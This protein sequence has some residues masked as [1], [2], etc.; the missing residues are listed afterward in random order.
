M[1]KQQTL[2]QQSTLAGLIERL[3]PSD[4]SHETDISDLYLTRSSTLHL[5]R[6]AL[7]Q[8]V[9]CIVA[10]GSKSILLNGQRY[11]YDPSTYL[12]VS[13]DLPL[14]GQLE[15]ASR[16]KP[17]LGWS[18]V[19]N[20][21]EID[22]LLQETKLQRPVSDPVPPR[23]NHRI[24]GRGTSRCCHSPDAAHAQA[25][26]NSDSGATHSPRNLLSLADQRT[27]W[28]ATTVDS[29]KWKKQTRC[30]R[31]GVA[32]T[33]R[34]SNHPDGRACSRTAYELLFN[35][36]LVSCSHIHEPATVSEAASP[37]G[38]QDA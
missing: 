6:T 37:P 38:K 27:Y 14:V 11:V 7:T 30:E 10:Q 13:L 25:C 3:S 32:E 17:F 1:Q 21:D 18:L 8:A 35:A 2:P 15:E 31:S 19:L 5:P 23:F 33:E 12:L 4:G 22:S 28:A 9:F 36:Q 29:R 26:S 34:I 24:T 16:A 20:F